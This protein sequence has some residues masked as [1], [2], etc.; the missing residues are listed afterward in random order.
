MTSDSTI[1]TFAVAVYLGGVLK[2]FIGA[3]TRD[4]IAPLFAPILPDAQKSASKVTVQLGP[5]LFFVGD[6]LAATIDLFIAMFVISLVLPYIRTYAPH[7]M[8]K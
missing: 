7:I 5:F 2:D 8:K 1:I 3:I 4:L 6:A